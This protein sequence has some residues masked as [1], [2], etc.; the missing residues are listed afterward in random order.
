MNIEILLMYDMNGS[1][2]FII[3]NIC[4]KISGDLLNEVESFVHTLGWQQEMVDL[5]TKKE[6]YFKLVR[7]I[8]FIRIFQNIHKSKLIKQGRYKREIYTCSL[9]LSYILQYLIYV[10]IILLLSITIFDLCLHYSLVISGL[11]TSCPT[12]E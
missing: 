6:G 5:I 4:V 8:F 3:I 2:C 1:I 7:G 12:T 10:C 9:Q 11:S